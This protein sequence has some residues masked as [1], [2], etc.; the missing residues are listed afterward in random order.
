MKNFYYL[1]ELS[2]FPSTTGVYAISFKNSKSKK[3]YVGSASQSQKKGGFYSRWRQHI[4]KLKKNI[5]DSKALQRACNK[6]S[7][8]N[9]EFMILE[10]CEPLLCTQKEQFY[11]DK[12]NSFKKGYN[13]RPKAM[14]NLGFKQSQKQKNT[15]KIKF[16]KIRDSYVSKIVELYNENKTTREISKILNISRGI[17]KKI[18]KENNIKGKNTVFYKR[19][20]F[21]QFTL[22][23]KLLKKWNS[24]HECTQSTGI[25][26]NSIKNVLKGKSRSA[27]GFYFNLNKLNQEE[28]FEKINILATDVNSKKAKYSNIKQLDKNKTLIKTWKDISEVVEFYKFS[29][30]NGI[31]KAILKKD[32]S[33]T[34][35]YKGYYWIL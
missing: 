28:T 34:G 35:Y 32:S 17:I 1:N 20:T 4:W 10:E 2:I 11:I 8:E 14:S 13:G 18:F 21:Y 25:Q 23:G 15:I 12:Y 19:T 7:I 3:I 16:K 6:Y 31:W 27:K 22:D 26:E 5:H 30:R 9:I 24:F 33:K 29:N